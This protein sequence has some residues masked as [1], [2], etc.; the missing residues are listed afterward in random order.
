MSKQESKSI[1]FLYKKNYKERKYVWTLV[2]IYFTQK[3]KILIGVSLTNVTDF[4]SLHNAKTVI[5][6]FH[7]EKDDFLKILCQCLLLRNAL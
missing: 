6:Q 3:K 5:S 7:K 1:S 4:N 2:W